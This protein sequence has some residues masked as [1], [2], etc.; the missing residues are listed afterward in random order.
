MSFDISKALQGYSG[1]NQKQISQSRQNNGS[2]CIEPAKRNKFIT[3]FYAN[4]SDPIIKILLCALAINFLT[5]FKSFNIFESSGI[6]FAVL[7][8]TI[9]STVSER[10]SENAFEKLNE[11]NSKS[12]CKVKRNNEII[13]VLNQELVVDDIV[14]I[15]A[16]EQIPADCVILE[17]ALSVNQSALTGETKEIEKNN[18]NNNSDNKLFKG[19][20]VYS[21]QA[22]AKVCAVGKNTYYGSL[23]VSLAEKKRVSPLKHRLS[24]LA[25]QISKLGFAAAL[26]VAFASI[27][28]SLFIDSGFNEYIIWQKLSDVDFLLRELLRAFTLAI[29]VIVVAVPEGLPMMITVVLSQNMKKMLND[30]ILVRKL[31]G[32]ETAGSLNILYTDK[33]GTITNGKMSLHNIILG[34]GN[35]YSCTK[36]LKGSTIFDYLDISVRS[37]TDCFISNATAV[38]GNST[39]RALFN[40]LSGKKKDNIH[41]IA[42]IPFSSERKFSAAKVKDDLWFIK[43]A[44]E[45]IL[46]H[47]KSYYDKNGKVVPLNN[48]KDLSLLL[49]ENSKNAIRS[50]AIATSKSTVM[51]DKIPSDLTLVA[52]CGLKDK[53]RNNAK[54]AVES[55]QNAGIKVVMIT[56]DGIETAKAI[57]KECNILR[58]DGVCIDSKQMSELQDSEL[59]KII[60]NLCVVARALPQD[61]TRLVKLSEKLGLVTGMTGDGINDS[62]A[63]KNSDVGFAM[64]S[65]TAVAKEA[66]DI[67]IT[68][69]NIYSI[70]KAVLYGRT[71]FKSIRKFITFQLTMN[72]C[73]VGISLIGPFIGIDT[74]VTVMQMLWINM[75]MDTLG[76]LA[77]AGEAPLNEYMQELPKS[78]SCPVINRYM[79]YQIISM[80]L[81]TVFL[82]VAF[83]KLSLI[84]DIFITQGSDIKFMTLFFVIFVFSGIFNCF[85]ART[86][87]INI[88]ANLKDNKP[89]ILIMSGITIIQTLLVYFGG[90]LFRT[91]P[92]SLRDFSNAVM[93]SAMVIPIDILRKITL[94]LLKKESKV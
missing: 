62:P 64:G 45:L 83:F 6:I 78:R 4:F 28:N 51:P 8:S 69:N 48:T 87:R 56:G 41:T 55:L 54:V 53:L 11:E 50:I 58:Q 71:I 40:G 90:E 32:I 49:N 47:V 43:G 37:N 59:M 31:V 84:K 66:G 24:I 61:K 12:F 76:G 25:N 21:G 17:G 46:A 23:A 29:T 34:N 89:F 88:F 57:A 86:C 79:F 1:L 5:L 60:P 74:P 63:L 14:V 65:G 19:S 9:I 39:D 67:V 94:K 36:D 26:L 10:G 16:G 42:K 22:I 2:N 35:T 77:F 85:N 82:Y 80:S 91:C 20:V 70:S 44:P 13:T 81:F 30:N 93:L 52:L 18:Q 73:A 33:T 3:D 38:G 75:I 7:L 68:D 72:L 92:I 15:G 27:F